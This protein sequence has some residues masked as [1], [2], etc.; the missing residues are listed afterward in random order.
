LDVDS[1]GGLVNGVAETADIIR[2]ARAIKPVTAVVD[3]LSGS[4]AYWL[5]AQ[6]THITAQRTS[7]IG[8]IG[9]YTVYVDS[10]EAAKERG[11]KVHIIR[12]GAH[13][14]TGVAGAPITEEQ[15][16]SLQNLIDGTAKYFT[17]AV[18]AGRN[19]KMKDIES[20]ATGELWLSD[21]AQQMGLIDSIYNTSAD[22]VQTMKGYVMANETE[23]QQMDAQLEVNRLTEQVQ[24]EARKV[25][26]ELRA[27]FKDDPDFAMLAFEKGWTLIEAKAEYCDKLQVKIEALDKELAALKAK[28]EEKKPKQKSAWGDGEPLVNGGTDDA[29]AISFVQAAKALAERKN[30]RLGD[31]YKQVAREQPELYQ[32]HVAATRTG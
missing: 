4:A 16:T 26:A 31:A 5:S 22:I 17:A 19:R 7:M 11:L 21:R 25:L 3:E 15:L 27:Y 28:A 12:S 13:K 29:G 32:Q 2:A 24:T 10:S 30:I 23:Q 1:P 14:G 8:S 20:W 6:A 9:V 18:A